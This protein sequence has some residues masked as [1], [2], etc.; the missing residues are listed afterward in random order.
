MKDL[1]KALEIKKT[2][3]MAYYYKTD[4]QVERIS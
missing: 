2:L 3:L 1:H 4:S